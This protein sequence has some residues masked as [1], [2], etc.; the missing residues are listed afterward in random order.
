MK[1]EFNELAKLSWLSFSKEEED[2]LISDMKSMI[3]FASELSGIEFDGENNEFQTVVERCDKTQASFEREEIL[4]NAP[5]VENGYFK[6]PD[7]SGI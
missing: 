1:N 6:L 2:I 5:T 3:S 7:N 4:K